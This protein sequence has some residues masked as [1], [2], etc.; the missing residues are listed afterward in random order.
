MIHFVLA[1][2]PTSQAELAC[3]PKSAWTTLM[4]GK[5]FSAQVYSYLR[6]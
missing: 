4:P 2:Q 6:A 5:K 1:G 3:F